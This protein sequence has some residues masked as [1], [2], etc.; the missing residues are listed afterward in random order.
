MTRYAEGRTLVNA[1]FSCRPTCTSLRSSDLE[2]LSRSCWQCLIRGTKRSKSAS[3]VSM[4]WIRATIRHHVKFSRSLYA[5]RAVASSP[6][7]VSKTLTKVE[8]LDFTTLC[9]VRSL[10]PLLGLLLLVA[11]LNN[12]LR[13]CANSP[14]SEDPAVPERTSRTLGPCES[15]AQYS[16]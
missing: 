2:Q 14:C 13:P 11:T 15:P 8:P 1:S 10:L 16:C 6:G 12:L 7:A 4:A 5:C 9:A 3:T